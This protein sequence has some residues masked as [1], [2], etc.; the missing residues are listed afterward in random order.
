M[1]PLPT[2]NATLRPCPVSPAEF[3]PHPQGNFC[4]QCQRVVHD[5]S[6]SH[7]PRADLYLSRS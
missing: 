7:A 3:A 6:Q 4:G 5:F 2:F 1:L